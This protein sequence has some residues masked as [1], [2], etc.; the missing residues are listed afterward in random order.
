M[1]MITLRAFGV[2][3]GGL[4]TEI[5]KENEIWSWM[6]V[7]QMAVGKVFSFSYAVV[8]NQHTF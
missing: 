3:L 1:P 7:Q 4:L 6:F 5:N 2:A 8:V